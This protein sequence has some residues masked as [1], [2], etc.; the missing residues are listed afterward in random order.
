VHVSAVT[1]QDTR[2]DQ[3]T[4]LRAAGGGA[5]STPVGSTTA[6]TVIVPCYN[7]SERLP[8]TLQALL[9]YLSGIPG[10]VEVLVVDDGSTDATVMV[11]EA[12][13]A[14]DRRVRVLSYQPNRGKGFAVR[15]GMLAAE[16]ELIVF[17]DADG[18][19]GPSDLDRI[20]R[21]LGEAPVAIGTRTSGTSGQV[22]RRTASR[23]FNLAIR[24]SLGLPFGDTQSGLKGFRRAAAQQIFSQARVDGFAFDVEVLWLARQ[25]KLEVAEVAVQAMERQGSKVRMLTDALGMLGEV[26]AVR[27]ASANGAYGNVGQA[28]NPPSNEAAAGPADLPLTAVNIPPGTPPALQ[29]T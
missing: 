16:G 9:A 17:T 6:L 8:D 26:W 11:A 2:S 4:I 21:A 23:V 13:A 24:G 27:Q 15:T 28:P 1:S 20:R 22:A 18:S 7:E 10:Q 5:A 14:V 12:V 3:S 25:L 19:Y 29:A